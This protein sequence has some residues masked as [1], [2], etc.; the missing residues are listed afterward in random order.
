MN[1][2]LKADL[3]LIKDGIPF[4]LFPKCTEMPNLKRSPRGADVLWAEHH[5]N[6]KYTLNHTDGEKMFFKVP[7]GN[8]PVSGWCINYKT[9]ELKV[10]CTHNMFPKWE[11]Y[12][13]EE[14]GIKL[15]YPNPSEPVFKY[16][17]QWLS[18]KNE[19]PDAVIFVKIGGFYELFHEDA[20][21]MHDNFDMVLMKGM[22]ARTAIPEVAVD[23][24]TDLVHS[25]NR[26]VVVI[27]V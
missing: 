26:Q 17:D 11:T 2:R 21:Y 22:Y 6:V 4:K 23:K 27:S 8:E 14:Y 19:L 13:P 20:V 24:Y 15:L 25:K 10:Y 5:Y 9:G 16:D 3:E 1:H 7:F 12:T 18:T